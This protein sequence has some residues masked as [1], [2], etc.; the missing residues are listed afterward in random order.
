L[1]LFGLVI[2]VLACAWADSGEPSTPEPPAKSN[3]AK[4]HALQGHIDAQRETGRSDLTGMN[5]TV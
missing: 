5:Q 3:E 4:G 2:F 1:P